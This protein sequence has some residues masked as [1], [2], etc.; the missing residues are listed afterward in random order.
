MKIRN[1]ITAALVLAATNAHAG[2]VY[3]CRPCEAGTYS[4]FGDQVC[5]KCPVGTHGIGKG[6]TECEQCTGDFRS[7][8]G[9]SACRNNWAFMNGWNGSYNIGMPSTLAGDTWYKIV[10]KGGGG[11]GGNGGDGDKGKNGDG[12]ATA[13]YYVYLDG[14]IGYSY[15]IGG[16]G[17]GGDVRR[18]DICG[19]DSGGSGG[20][21]YIDIAGQRYAANGGASGRGGDWGWSPVKAG[22]TNGGAGQNSKYANGGGVSAGYGMSDGAGGSWGNQCAPKKDDKPKSGNSGHIAIYSL[23][24]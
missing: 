1:V 14:D 6:N 8:V 24:K 2:E 9:E 7:Y 11:G 10:L 16:G 19:G 13:V 12:G 23:P 17:Q 3:L 20:S 4:K 15:G 18:P 5:T 21:T 22:G